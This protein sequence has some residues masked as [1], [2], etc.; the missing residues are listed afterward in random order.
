MANIMSKC[1]IKQQFCK[2]RI[3]VNFSALIKTRW[4]Y[5]RLLEEL[6]L[7]KGLGARSLVGLLLQTLSNHLTEDFAI[8][9][10]LLF[11]VGTRLKYGWVIL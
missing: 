10:V 2:G 9:F 5:L 8:S 1:L 4:T 3:S 7:E 6:V 11:V